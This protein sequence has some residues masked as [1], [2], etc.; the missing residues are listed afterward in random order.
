[1]SFFNFPKTGKSDDP[2][3]FYDAQLIVYDL[4][5][6]RFYADFVISH[7]YTQFVCKSEFAKDE[8]RAH[9]LMQDEDELPAFEWSDGFN[10]KERVSE[11]WKF[12]ESENVW[13]AKG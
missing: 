4:M 13:T 5:E 9:N 2:I 3:F 8:F 10:F 12:N 1:M 11:S 7:D 6:G